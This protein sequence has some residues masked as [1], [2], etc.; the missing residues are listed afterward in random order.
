[1]TLNKWIIKTGPKKVAKLLRVD[2]GTVSQWKTL[3]ACPRPRA[4]VKIHQL[5]KKQVS[6]Q[7]MIESFVKANS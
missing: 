4:M 2:P 7:S 3:D 5:S 6:Y 1:M